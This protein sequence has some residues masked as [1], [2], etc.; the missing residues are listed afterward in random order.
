MLNI[1]QNKKKILRM[2]LVCFLILVCICTVYYFSRLNN[3][4][5]G[6]NPNQ[7]ISSM[8]LLHDRVYVELKKIHKDMRPDGFEMLEVTPGT[9]LIIA[10]EDRIGTYNGEDYIYKITHDVDGNMLT[11]IE[12]LPLI[13]T[14][15]GK[16]TKYREFIEEGDTEHFE[17][18]AV[19][20]A[21]FRDVSIDVVGMR[22]FGT[23]PCN[24]IHTFDF[25]GDRLIEV[26]TYQNSICQKYTIEGAKDLE[27]IPESVVAAARAVEIYQISPETLEKAKKFK[28]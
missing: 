10:S 5:Y 6:K 11:A 23:F 21:Y 24:L 15:G 17:S 27:K 4:I 28:I 9:S 3:E 16:I 25:Y 7:E 14:Q 1:L 22:P 18:N 2:L 26:A 12:G 8:E 13:Q 20:G 19:T